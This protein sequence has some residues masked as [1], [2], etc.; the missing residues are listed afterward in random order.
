MLAVLTC[1]SQ[2]FLYVNVSFN[3]PEFL[4]GTKVEL[5][6]TFRSLGNLFDAPA[7]Q[8]YF[9]LLAKLN[10]NRAIGK[11]FKLQHKA[12]D[13]I[14]WVHLSF[15]NDMA[16]SSQILRNCILHAPIC[17]WILKYSTSLVTFCSW[18]AGQLVV[19]ETGM[20]QTFIQLAAIYH[21]FAVFGQFS[22]N[23]MSRS[24]NRFSIG[25]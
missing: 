17:K 13:I 2:I 7:F 23:F 25:W 20:G 15:N 14:C 24:N 9:E 4:D 18:P 10:G 6:Q 21:V 22:A 5:K 1:I 3:S 16:E 19:Q 12:T 11:R 8:K